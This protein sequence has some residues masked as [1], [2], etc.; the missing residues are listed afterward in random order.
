MYLNTFLFHEGDYKK[1]ES[2][3]TWSPKIVILHP[4]LVPKVWNAPTALLDR[5][6]RLFISMVLARPQFYLKIGRLKTVP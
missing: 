1:E 4:S 6:S 5:V 3:E 2:K